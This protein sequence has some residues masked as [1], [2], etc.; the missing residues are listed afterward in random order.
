MGYTKT[1]RSLPGGCKQVAAPQ[2][3]HL[4]GLP[5]SQFVGIDLAQTPIA[6]GQAVIIELGLQNIQLTALDV[7]TLPRDL[8]QFDYIIAL[9]L[10]DGSRDRDALCWTNGLAPAIYGRSNNRR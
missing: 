2:C 5:D 3:L 4:L 8:G 7:R 1:A 9:Q 6:E 10:M